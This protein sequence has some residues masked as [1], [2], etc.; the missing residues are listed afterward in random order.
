MII[1]DNNWFNRGE[2]DSCGKIEDAA[3]NAEWRA[4]KFSPE[5]LQLN[6]LTKHLFRT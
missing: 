2:I 4:K 6:T 3:T 5:K 1:Q